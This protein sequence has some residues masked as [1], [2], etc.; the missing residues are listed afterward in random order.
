MNDLLWPA[1]GVYEEITM[2]MCFAWATVTDRPV[3]QLILSSEHQVQAVDINPVWE[4][5]SLWYEKQFN[6]KWFKKDI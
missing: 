4:K 6:K 3:K 2:E 1:D 5:A